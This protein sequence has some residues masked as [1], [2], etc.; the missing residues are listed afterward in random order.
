MVFFFLAKSAAPAATLFTLSDFE[1]GTTQGWGAG[2][3]HPQPP[4]VVENSGPG[5]IQDD[6]LGVF[7]NGAAGPGGKLVAFNESPAWTG[8]YT[9]AGIT[10]VTVDLRNTGG[11]T[12][13][14][15]LALD[16]PGGRYSS[17]TAITLGTPSLWTAASFALSSADLIH[18]SGTGTGVLADTLA[19]VQQIRFIHNPNPGYRGIQAP[20]SFGLDNITS[21]PEPSTA[22]L[23][24]LAGGLLAGKRR[25]N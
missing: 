4:A 13:S 22:G 7:S 25:R 2:A 19:D 6:R 18:E 15:R 8:D 12:L 11:G 5:G 23:A 3:P 16:G 1:D 24:L 10:G 20:G 17:A 21:I 9:T 14:I